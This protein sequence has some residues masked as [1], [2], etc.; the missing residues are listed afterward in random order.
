M[1]LFG[2]KTQAQLSE[3]QSRNESLINRIKEL[4][5]MLTPEMKEIEHLKSEIS[6]LQM[7]KQK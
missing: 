2:K 6:N 3:M 7:E 5:A 1:D 4:E